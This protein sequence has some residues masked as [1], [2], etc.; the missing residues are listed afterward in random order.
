MD[1]YPEYDFY[2]SREERDGKGGR[3]EKEDDMDGKMWKVKEKEN[4]TRRPT[5]QDGKTRNFQGMTRERKQVPKGGVS[6]GERRG[7]KES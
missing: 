4:K 2:N 3:G 1:E 7:E 5:G 6:W